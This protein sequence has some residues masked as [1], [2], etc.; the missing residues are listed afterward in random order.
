MTDPG[1]TVR[2]DYAISHDMSFSPRLIV[3]T[4]NSG[5]RVILTHDGN[6]RREID[7]LILKETPNDS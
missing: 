7:R 6:E 3:Y 1:D 2:L 4:E 5:R